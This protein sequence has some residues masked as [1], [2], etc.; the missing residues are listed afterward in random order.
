MTACGE[1]LY[2]ELHLLASS[3]RIAYT[4]LSEM[5][6]PEFLRLVWKLA[7]ARGTVE[8]EVLVALMVLTAIAMCW[9]DA[10]QFRRLLRRG[11][12]ERRTER[13]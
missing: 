12:E 2:L 13:N 8:I 1:P 3:A 9:W 6:F 10:R 5:S 11:Q 4:A 7:W